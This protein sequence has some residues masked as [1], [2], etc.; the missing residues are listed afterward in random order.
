LDAD[1]QTTAARVICVDKGERKLYFI[2]DGQ[3]VQRLDARF[4]GVAHPTREGAFSI[5]RKDR[6]HT[7]TLYGSNMPFA[8]FFS[9][10]EAVHF[11]I[12]FATRGYNGHS[13]GCVNIRDREGI[14]WLFD[15]VPVD[16]PI[17]IYD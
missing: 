14:A 12:D 15:R 11:S 9:R 7:S 13:H 2:V 3:I 4:G 1:C 8:M 10:G 17:Y 5:Y 16:T 6:D